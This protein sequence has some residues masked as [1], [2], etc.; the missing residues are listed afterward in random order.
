MAV[1]SFNAFVVSCPRWWSR[2]LICLVLFIP[3]GGFAQADSVVQADVCIY[4]GTSAGIIAAYTV[5]KL[6]KSVIVI[7][8]GS[9]VGGMSVSGSFDQIRE[10]EIITG[11]ARDF[12]RRVGKHYNKLEQWS[13]EPHVGEAVFKDYIDRAGLDILMQSSIVEVRKVANALV[14]V[15]AQ[16]ANSKRL[17]VRA[18]MFIDCSY[19]GDLMAMSGVPFTTGREGNGTYSETLNG[20]Q[21]TEHNQFPD[22]IDPFKESGKAKSGIL[23]GLA[24]GKFPNGVADENFHSGQFIVC[25]TSEPANRLPITQPV[26]YS[27]ERYELLLRSILSQPGRTKLSD[28]FRFVRLPNSKSLLIGEGMFPTGDVNDDETHLHGSIEQRQQTAALQASFTRGLLYFLTTDDRLPASIRTEMKMWG[29]PADEFVSSNHWPYQL[30]L[31]SSRR[32]ISDYVITQANLEGKRRAPDPVGR[33]PVLSQAAV[34]RRVIIGRDVKNEGT[35]K[36]PDRPPFEIPYRAIVPREKDCLNLLVPVCMST[37]YVAEPSIRPEAVIMMMG[38]AAA[39]AAVLAINEQ[40]TI[41]QIHTKRLLELLHNNPLADSSLVEV[42]VDNDDGRH[43]RR[44]GKQWAAVEKRG[45]GKSY[46]AVDPPQEKSISVKKKL[47]VDAFRFSPAI[48]SGGNYDVYIFIPKVEKCSQFM[49]VRI[50]NGSTVQER[51]LNPSNLVVD[52]DSPGEWLSLGRHRIE[53]GKHPFVEITNLGAN[54]KVMA[55]AVLW[56][57]CAADSLN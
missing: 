36:L 57:P 19:E 26:D 46:L 25:L 28:H 29:F 3:N 32:M 40:V 8:P 6:G 18:R 53:K 51:V 49:T 48:R 5:K 41:Q 24:V 31:R 39:S 56:V 16:T 52:E 4:G 10:K 7:E 37:S 45:Y 13:Y 38:Q 2:A 33:A 14:Y 47:Q 35:F 17:Q 54:G 15:V 1:P 12:Y 22:G 23:D 42:L 34:A 50:S 43:T 11:L 44:S 55:D 21:I 27:A 9:Y 20:I 30:G